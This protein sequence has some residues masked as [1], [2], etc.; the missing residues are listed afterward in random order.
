MSVLLP[1]QVMGPLNEELRDSLR[2]GARTGQREKAAKRIN[3]TLNGLARQLGLT[4]SVHMFGSFSNGFKTGTS[5]LDVVFVGAIEE[6]A[7]TILQKF[8]DRLD[9]LGFD[10]I[11]KIFQ[12]TVPILKLTDRKDNM[13]VD[14]CINNELGVR[15]SL[16]LNTYC[17]YDHR[18]LQLGRLIKEWAKKHELVGVADGCINSYA[19]MLLVV[20]FLQSV[21]PPV[22][23]NLQAMDCESVPVSDR[24]WG[25]EDIWETKFFFD[26]EN[27]PKSQNQ[28]S[29]GELL[30][31]FFRFYTREFN[32]RQHAVC[33]RL[34]KPGQ[35][36]D[37]YSLP[38]QTNEE[39]WYLEDPFDLKHNLAGKCSRAGKKRF[40]DEMH[41][42]LNVLT[43]GGRWAKCLPPP[44]G[45]DYFMKCRISQNVTPQAL[46]EEFEQ[47][48]LVK[49]HFPKS[50]GTVRMPQAFLQFGDAISRRKAHAK[51]EKYIMD[52][53]LQLHYSSQHSLAEAIQQCH[54]STYEMASY[55]MQRQVLAARMG[56]TQEMPKSASAPEDSLPLQMNRAMKEMSQ[57]AMYSA[58]AAKIP[59]PPPPPPPPA[60]M[61]YQMQD[62]MAK[63]LQMRPVMAKVDSGMPA[64]PPP[65]HMPLHGMRPPGAPPAQPKTNAPPPQ[66]RQQ[67]PKK[68][69]ARP[70]NKKIETKIKKEP[71]ASASAP[72]SAK[73][74]PGGH[75]EPGECWLEVKVTN[76]LSPEVWNTEPFIK[77]KDLHSFFQK[78]G[79]V[80]MPDVQPEIKLKVEVN[81]DF[82]KLL[83]LFVDS[84]LLFE[85]DGVMELEVAT[86]PS[87]FNAPYAD[88]RR[89]RDGA[90]VLRCRLC[91]ICAGLRERTLAGGS[92]MICHFNAFFHGEDVREPKIAQRVSHGGYAHVWAKYREELR[93]MTDEELYETIAKGR[94]M[95]LHHRMEKF[96]RKAPSAGS[97]YEWQYKIAL[98]KTFLKQR[99][100]AATVPP[101]AGE[102][103]SED[104]PD[105]PTLAEWMKENEDLEMAENEW[106]ARPGTGPWLTFQKL[107]YPREIA[108][109]KRYYEKYGK[110]Y[111]TKTQIGEP[112]KKKVVD[113]KKARAEARKAKT[114]TEAVPSLPQV[115]GMGSLGAAVLAGLG[116]AAATRGRRW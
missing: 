25:G 62:P 33:M 68:E 57:E 46:L 4:G 5:D 94:R 76:N 64:W 101:E 43:S 75:P 14:F 82:T 85:S 6:S 20:F 60:M 39:Q 53:Q 52:C 87:H 9:S 54:F 65:N 80:D 26:V 19:Y 108:F 13:E 48:D 92:G 83:V 50:D 88:C 112:F 27:L 18:V 49:L 95:T 22:V 66:V 11:T 31:G 114:A 42:T 110:E 104:A 12:A 90:L 113:L 73:V 106:Y 36:V 47:C 103:L 24:K 100:I 69:P 97:L 40:V 37:K 86:C 84:L 102:P 51:N 41:N 35:F 45:M 77:L 98:A 71:N 59:P 3:L 96:R 34:Q 63:Q 30:V 111:H 23:P 7:I 16:L 29:I 21:Q 56:Q 17:K 115:P 109:E 32:W 61:D 116:L 70:E 67:V 91:G 79:S 15:N 78:Y 1:E 93:S 105:R 99:E 55:K 8:A 81:D 74:R 10:N 28:M 58:F 2:A 38:L 107:E 72:S 44:Q 89:L